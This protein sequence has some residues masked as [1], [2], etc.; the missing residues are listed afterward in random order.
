M[1][2]HTR[3]RFCLCLGLVIALLLLCFFASSVTPFDPYVQNLNEALQPP[4]GVHI[5]GTDRYGR[6]LFSRVL[7]GGKVTVFS[8]LAVVLSATLFGSFIGIMCGLHPGKAATVLMRVADV[9]L[10]FPTMV[11][12]IAVAGILGGGTLNA[13]LAIVL[14]AWPKYTRL[15]SGLVRPLRHAPFMEAARMSGSSELE[16]L[17]LVIG[18]IVV[19][20][21][22]D[23]GTVIAELAGLSF[24]GL[25]TAPPA[26]EWG[27][28]M[29]GS[30]SLLQSAPWTVLAPGLGIFV[31]VAIFQLFADALR[32][33]VDHSIET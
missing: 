30:R 33:V 8:A 14:V 24:L 27:S 10:A 18:P 13:A 23:V 19:T 11:F 1:T 6:D 7:A 5:L 15:A 29:S 4:G 26:A 22:L 32:D 25:G 16:V 20:A 2:L 21:A 28:M 17:P 31:T 9:F 3:K 12:A